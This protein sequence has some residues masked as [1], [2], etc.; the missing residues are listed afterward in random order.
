M[1]T[2]G[3]L[4]TKEILDF[5]EEHGFAIMV[6][7]DGNKESHD[8]N[9]VFTN[10][11][12]TFDVIIHNLKFLKENYPK[13]MKTLNFNVVMDSYNK[14]KDID[15]F[16][17]TFDAVEEFYSIKNSFISDSY[18]D[19]D[20]DVSETFIATR[21]YEIFKLLASKVGRVSEKNISK[22]V[23]DYYVQLYFNMFKLRKFS[24]LLP[25][26]AHHGGPCVP[27]VQR[28][29]VN[30]DGNFFPCE[31][32]SEE[33]ELVNIGNIVDGFNVEK[34]I[35]ILNVGQLT[36]NECRNCWNFRFCNLCIVTADNLTKL[37][38]DEKLRN[39]RIAKQ[40]SIIQLLDYC[41][42]HELGHDFTA[43]DFVD[44][45]L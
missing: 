16:Y 21:N 15:E 25:D 5:L 24:N 19:G 17:S 29:F 35:K 28:F 8:K 27:G 36:D 30:V 39:C 26:K 38:K 9:R 41:T 10:G 14:F 2:N 3:T 13:L 37:S 44:Y 33:S 43:T 4:L 34:V 6:S 40:S 12:G 32:V 11:K 42:L 23:K 1:T 45:R 31:R 20:L 18:R 7:L 22:L